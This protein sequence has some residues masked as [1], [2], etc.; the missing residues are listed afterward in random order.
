MIP[1]AAPDL[2]GNEETYAS[3]AIRSSWVSSSGAFL[4]RFESEFAEKCQAR[5]CLAVSN[6][7]VAI[8]LALLALGVEADDE[9]I[10]PALTY[11]ATANA[12]RYVNAT[13]VFCDVDPKTWCL[14]PG[15]IQELIT[16]KTKAIVAVHLYGHPADMDAINA[17]AKAHGL[18]VVEDAAEA[19]FAEYKGRRVGSLSDIAT[20][21]FFGNKILTCGEGGAVTLND[22]ELAAKA[23]SLKNQ[24][25][26]PDFR[27]FH[28]TIGYN[29][30]LTNVAAA[31]LCAQLERAEAMI[32]RRNEIF[33][34][35]DRY[36]ADLPGIGVQ[37]VANWAKRAPWMYCVTIDPDTFGATRDQVAEYLRTNGFDSRPLFLGIHEQPPYRD[38]YSARPTDLTVTQRLSEEGLSLPTY[39]GLEDEQVAAISSCI[40]SMP[41]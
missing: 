20:F 35:Y 39:V 9:V 11:I 17:I 37:P 27:Y 5:N 33:A 23:A 18:W 26:V 32:A 13:P 24:G 38:I 6:G 14:D 28:P 4:D 30:R 21:S 29:Y 12:V 19:H 36:F 7:T 8:H 41:R 15:R 34:G 22:A 3:E 10:V 31:L 1:V 16:P 2:S 40:V 25:V